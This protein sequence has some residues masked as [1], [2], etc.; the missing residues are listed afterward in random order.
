VGTFVVKPFR[1]CVHAGQ[2]TPSEAQEIC[3]LLQEVS[4][5]VQ[6]V[7]KAEQVYICSWSHA[8]FQPVHMHFIVQPAW[9]AWK[10]KYYRPGPFVQAEMFRA[11]HSS[12]VAEV[13]E[14]C[15]NVKR[16]MEPSL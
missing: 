10:K 9:N 3:P 6:T 1:H 11:G 16:L 12:E 15:R 14:V 8:G 5:V 2:L 13:E 7:T 4:R